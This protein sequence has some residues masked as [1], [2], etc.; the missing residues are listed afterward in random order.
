[1]KT[2]SRNFYRG[3]CL[4]FHVYPTVWSLGNVVPL[5]MQEMKMMYELGLG[6]NSMEGREA[7]HIAIAMC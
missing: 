6:L 5:H 3:Y 4:Y 7:K 2:H 1:M